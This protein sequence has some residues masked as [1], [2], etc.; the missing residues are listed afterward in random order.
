LLLPP[1]FLHSFSSHPTDRIKITRNNVEVQL[2]QRFSL[3]VTSYHIT[4]PFTWF[5]TL[6][7]HV[8]W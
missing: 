8:L 6:Y 7:A 4:F 5:M 2:W 1:L 3:G